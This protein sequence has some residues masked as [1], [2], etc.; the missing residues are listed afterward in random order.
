MLLARRMG[1]TRIIAE[2]SR[3]ARSSAATK[4]RVARATREELEL[5]T[6]RVLTARTLDEVFSRRR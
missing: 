1:K 4:T 5:W 6:E 2:T 3:L